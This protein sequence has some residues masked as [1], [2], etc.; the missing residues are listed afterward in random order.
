MCIRD[1]CY[2]VATDSGLCWGR[3]AFRKTPGVI[4]IAVLAPL[5]PGLARKT[6]M[7]TL[8]ARIEAETARLMAGKGVVD[9]SGE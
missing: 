5:P 6:L 8:E 1:S 9:K 3:R 2:P 7:E 4:S